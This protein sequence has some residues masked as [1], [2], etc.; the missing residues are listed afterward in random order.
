MEDMASPFTRT[1]FRCAQF[2]AGKFRSTSSGGRFS[3]A[4]ITCQALP[5][6]VDRTVEEIVRNL[7]RGKGL[8][9][10]SAHFTGKSA[11][12]IGFI[13]RGGKELADEIGPAVEDLAKKSDVALRIIGEGKV[14]EEESL[15]MKPGDRIER[16]V[17]QLK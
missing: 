17:P 3:F 10:V 7:L 5:R 12:G 11:D 4:L 2:A 6:E 9:C 15:R 1:I 8:S 16:G 13:A 14:R